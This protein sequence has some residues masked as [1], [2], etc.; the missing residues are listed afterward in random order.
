ME[1]SPDLRL[2]WSSK[3][4]I[5]DPSFP[6]PSMI[7]LQCQEGMKLCRVLDMVLKGAQHL[8]TWTWNK[9]LD[10]GSWWDHLYSSP[11]DPVEWSCISLLKEEYPSIQSQSLYALNDSPET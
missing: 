10:G 2:Q 5:K 6:H 1:Q 3:T 4:R 11:M 7:C 8:P 9:L